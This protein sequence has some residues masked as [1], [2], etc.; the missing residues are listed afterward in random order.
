MPAVSKTKCKAY[1][2][3]AS[4]FSTLYGQGYKVYGPY[5]RKQDGRKIVIVYDG[6]TRIAKQYAK[7]KLEIKLG[8]LLSS[9]D[10]V[11]HIDGRKNND[12]FSNLQL[13][14]GTK[15]RQKQF[16]EG[17]GKSPSPGLGSKNHQAK[18][19]E[20]DIRKIRR[21]ATRVEI[22]SI[23]DMFGVHPN[24]ISKIVKRQRWAQVE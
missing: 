10:E 23:A 21:L 8:R 20:K 7:V 3:F 13:L 18:L 1:T 24:T 5:K 19:V 4:D 14:T 6:L 16:K 2:S 12:R 17:N 15:N 11:D 22:R 9:K